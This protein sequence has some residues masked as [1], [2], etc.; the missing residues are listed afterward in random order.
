[1][2]KPQLL[3]DRIY[4]HQ[5]RPPIATTRPSTL[6][7]TI[8]PLYTMAP[9]GMF[10]YLSAQE[11]W[12]IKPLQIESSAISCA[13]AALGTSVFQRVAVHTD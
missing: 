2:L 8:N 1:M 3:G 9:P 12:L 6:T 5:A 11:T 10:N 4:K 7:S 13:S